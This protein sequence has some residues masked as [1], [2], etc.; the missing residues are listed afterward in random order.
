MM[1]ANK[2][3][4]DSRRFFNPLMVLTAI[5]VLAVPLL[6]AKVDDKLPAPDGQEANM[7]QPVQVFIIMGQSNTL[8]MGK[9][10]GGDGSLEHAVKQE[11]LYPFMVDDD[12]NCRQWQVCQ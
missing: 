12:E 8:E 9:V 6:Q 1:N 7:S 3:L 10:S 4:I 11:G 2:I 5:S